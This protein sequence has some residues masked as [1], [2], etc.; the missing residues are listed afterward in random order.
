[1]NPTR[2]HVIEPVSTFLDRRKAVLLTLAHQIDAFMAMGYTE[3]ELFIIWRPHR[4]GRGYD[5]PEVVPAS[6]VAPNR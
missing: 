6:I 1:M 5:N 2:G 3:K 4:S